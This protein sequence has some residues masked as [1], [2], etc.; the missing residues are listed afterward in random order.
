[1]GTLQPGDIETI[2]NQVSRTLE[3]RTVIGFQELER[4][5]EERLQNLDI[6]PGQ[7]ALGRAGLQQHP[8]V[9]LSEVQTQLVDA[10]EDLTEQRKLPVRDLHE[11]KVLLQILQEPDVDKVRSIA[12][13]RLRT[14]YIANTRSWSQATAYARREL[15]ENLGLPPVPPP[16]PRA[17]AARQSGKKK[18]A[19]KKTSMPQGGKK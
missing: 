14:L 13:E 6:G 1:M 18:Y 3:E 16:P 4:R 5:L 19:Q 9:R 11:T 12:T 15:D 7:G 2:V 17:P 10:L 8:Q